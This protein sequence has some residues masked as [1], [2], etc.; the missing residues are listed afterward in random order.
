MIPG[1]PE[2]LT[3]DITE[4][5]LAAYRSLTGADE[6]SSR[7]PRGCVESAASSAVATALYELE[8]DAPF[9][10]LNI[11]LVAAKLLHGLSR[12]HC[13]P[14]GNK[15]IS[16]L[17]ARDALLRFGEIG[18]AATNDD[19]Q[20]FMLGVAAGR[21][22]IQECLDWLLEHISDEDGPLDPGGTLI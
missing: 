21:T 14:D 12:G 15:R 16:W 8:A 22:G 4:Y 3:H 2:A 20:A 17:T 18:I 9:E 5:A 6:F 19:A 10:D 11:L 1:D 13:F 7:T